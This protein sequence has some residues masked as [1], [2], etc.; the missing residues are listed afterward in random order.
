MDD[1]DTFHQLCTTPGVRKYLFDDE[2]LSREQVEEFLQISLKLFSESGYGLW[3]MRLIGEEV[4]SGFCGYWFF[5]DPPELELIYA[6]SESHWGKGLVVEAARAVM[7]YGFAQ[8]GFERIQAS[9]DAPNLAS[10]RVMEKL[11]MQFVKRGISD[12]LDT[13]YYAIT[14]NT[15][16]AGG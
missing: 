14:R 10:F 9:A 6:V 11:G 13:I 16:N 8:L 15:F 4:L 5:H 2:R 1:A 7:E 12:G 3:A